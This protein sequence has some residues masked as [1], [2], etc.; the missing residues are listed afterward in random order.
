MIERGWRGRKIG[1]D[2]FRP[3]NA[4]PPDFALVALIV[5]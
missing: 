4:R 1:V 2:L 3:G 5:S